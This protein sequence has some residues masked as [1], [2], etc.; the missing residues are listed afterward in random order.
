MIKL[1]AVGDI[2]LCGGYTSMLPIKGPDFP[3]SSIVPYFRQGDIVFGNL[4][5][6]LSQKGLP[7]KSKPLS[8]CGPPQ[9][10]DALASAGFTHIS[11]ANNHAYDYG[12]EALMDTQNRLIKSGIET[13]GAGID[14]AGARKPA[15]SSFGNC[16]VAFLAYN[17]YTT[18]GR[19]YADK[20]RG[21]V[22]PLEYK[23]VSSD[24]K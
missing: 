24:I 1:Y 18:N 14:L 8:F 11:M 13:M 16:M 10:I 22:S 7:D 5:V 17:S 6:P 21:G 3:F 20:T 12:S 2:A 4:E 15:V 23:Y 19:G 9:G